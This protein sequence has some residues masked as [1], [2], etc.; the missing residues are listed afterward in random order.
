MM[1]PIQYVRAQIA[2]HR[3]R[4][5]VGK[6]SEQRMLGM[7]PKPMTKTEVK[8]ITPTVDIVALTTDPKFTMLLSTSAMSATIR[9]G[10]VDSSR[11]LQQEHVE[12]YL[13]KLAADKSYKHLLKTS[14]QVL[15]LKQYSEN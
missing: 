6:I 7:T 1:F 10:I 11:D 15:L 2:M 5:R 4:T 14:F 13:K 9:I 3:P 8:T 12:Y